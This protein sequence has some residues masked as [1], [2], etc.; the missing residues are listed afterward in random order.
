[1]S[2]TTGLFAIKGQHLEKLSEVFDTFKLVDSGN[3]K[4][5]N[6][7][8]SVEDLFNDE[9]QSP[10]IDV[11][12]RTVWFDNGW[13]II[14]DISFILCTNEVALE[15]L[16]Q[17]LNSPVFSLLTQ[18][19]SSCYA[20]WYFDKSKQRSF[21]NDDG[22]VAD[23]FGTPLQEENKFKINEK[24]SYNDIHGVARELGIDWAQAEKNDKFIV[25]EL[26]NS[27]ELNKELEQFEQLQKQHMKKTF[28]KPWWKIW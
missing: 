11:Q 27:D 17:K 25:K 23:N 18:G 7:W 1:M 24:T 3:D 12:H 21:F 10:E 14:E 9:F 28:D 13:T 26:T 15:K 5:F 20:F 6:S 2:L 4:I 22:N 8:S 19:T 16:S